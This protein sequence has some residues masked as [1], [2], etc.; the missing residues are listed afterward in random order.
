M[1][2]VEDEKGNRLNLKKSYNYEKTGADKMK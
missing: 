2:L 1:I